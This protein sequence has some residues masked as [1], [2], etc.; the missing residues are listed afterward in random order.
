MAIVNNI[1]NMVDL[2]TKKYSEKL[3]KMKKD[4]ARDTKSMSEGFKGIGSAVKALAATVVSVSFANSIKKE[5][6]ETEKSV[7]GLI[8]AFGGLKAARDQ[9]EMLQQA[10]RDT[11]QPF[12]QLRAVAMNLK[13]NGIQATAEQMK[14]FSQIAYGTGQSLETVGNAFTSA[15]QGRV[16]SLNQLGIVAKD[17]G[18]K[19]ILTYKGVTTTV[20]KS[21]E[22][23]GKYFETLG[24]ENKGALEYLQGGMTGAMNHL[25]N[26]WGDFIRGIAESGLGQAIAD[27]IRVGANALDGITAWISRNKQS[28]QRFFDNWSW[29]VQKLGQDFESLRQDMENWLETAEKVKKSGG[30]DDDVGVL[31]WLRSFGQTAGEKYF[32]L[33]NGSDAER[34]YKAEK[35]RAK[36]L[37]DAR[38][39]G[40]KKGTEQYEKEVEKLN[41]QIVSIERK[42]S[43][44]QTT[45]FGRFGKFFDLDDTFLKLHRNLENTSEELKKYKEKQ[46]YL[47]RQQELNEE[48]YR[49]GDG[50]GGD[51]GGGGGGLGGAPK[52]KLLDKW[53]DYFERIKDMARDGWSDIDKLQYDYE[54]KLAELDT[55]FASS[56]L[57]TESEY[58]QA[59]EIINQ[60]FIRSYEELQKQAR[61]FAKGLIGDE[62]TD[63]QD[64]YREKLELLEKHHEDSLISEELYLQARQALYNEYTTE[65]TKQTQKKRGKNSFFS[66][67]DLENIQS[68]TDGLDSMTDAFSNLT[69]GMSESSATYRALFAIQKS[70]A[71]ASATMNAIVAWSQA[72]SDSTQVSWIAKLA[73]Y[74]NAVAMT[75]N[76]IGQLKSVTMHDKGGY[77]PAGGLGIVGEYGPEL[78]RGP[79]N[80][81]S[82]RETADL[83]RSALTGG[84]K[85]TVN[86]IED[87]SRAG[88]VDSRERDGDEVINIFVSNIRKGGQM[89]K[90]LESTY[91]LRRY[92][93]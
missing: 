10:A 1:L 81:T 11:I 64:S 74:A 72:L 67:Q 78:V 79:A 82:R 14:T 46:E 90:T 28:I 41:Q 66:D 50:D 88:Q 8:G 73:Q 26:A 83:A 17:N 31:G 71:V 55:Q 35:E 30:D 51:G 68:L 89:A 39:Q 63:L 58:L 25:E 44:E 24:E 23:L 56:R 84:S 34:A 65:L 49:S 54:K 6:M 92:G 2:N 70:F 21:A 9:F 29:W 77:I 15:L 16:K 32:E 85:V 37:F 18:D 12:D 61:D 62:L 60:D 76:I 5:L 57:A 33:F 47:K 93:A 45:V 38:T 19:L 3:K 52:P 75:T 4:T 91:A 43:N 27:T 48:F 80:V 22:G 53:H 86:L 13:R 69:Q 7:A 87:Q 59:K 20:E 42:Y 36:T 40:L